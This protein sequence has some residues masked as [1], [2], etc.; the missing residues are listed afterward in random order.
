MILGAG[1]ASR[2]ISFSLA[3]E[4][5]EVV[6]LNRTLEKA[7]NLVKDLSRVFGKKVGCGKLCRSRLMKELKDADLLINATSSGMCPNEHETPVNKDLLRPDLPVFD[8]VYDPPETRLL[9]EAK[10]VGAKTIDGLTMLIY[11]GAISFEI[12]TGKTAPIAVM[13]KAAWESLRKQKGD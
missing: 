10:S 2:A 7:E 11:Q 5:R 8:L 6:I 1:G 3:R 4:A 12:W 9:R 13:M